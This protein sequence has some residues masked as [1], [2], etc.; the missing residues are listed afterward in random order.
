MNDRTFLKARN[1]TKRYGKV[2]ALDDVSLDIVEGEFLTL[3]GPSGSGKT[4]FLMCL[5]GFVEPSEGV[6][7]QNGRD[8]THMPAE[9][10]RFGMVFQGYALFPH[11]TVAR[12][13]DFPLRVVGRGKAERERLVSDML[14]TVGLEG[15][16]QRRP[17]EL[18]GGQQQRVAL[19]RALVYEPAV[20]LLDEPLS[21]LDKNLR[22]QMQDEIRSLHRKAS[23]TFVF[24]THDQT[25]ALSM[26]SRV[27]IFNRGRIQQ[28]GTPQEVYEKPANR[29][30]AQF[31]GRINLVPLDKAET[32]GSWMTGSFEGRTLVSSTG[33]ET[34]EEPVIAVRPEHMTLDRREP[35]NDMNAVKA[36]VID[37][38]YG[39]AHSVLQLRCQSGLELSL[40]VG[41]ADTNV[42]VT[43]GE[44]VWVSW[45]KETGFALSA[46]DQQQ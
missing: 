38:A 6:L 22:E 10:R 3:L 16:S 19:A 9:D 20:T 34:I 1:I 24:V 45:P 41:S 36:T 39:G 29:F 8:I 35:T 5:A 7:E 30:V 25:E 18:S 11:M 15:L 27:A 17:S 44:T 32:N 40:D 28:I 12:N 46:K 26:S 4:T 13:V 21:A 33:G 42:P 37:Y 43:P 14:R 31:L 23:G 2:R